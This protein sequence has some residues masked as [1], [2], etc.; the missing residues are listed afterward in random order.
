MFEGYVMFMKAFSLSEIK[1]ELGTLSPARVMALCMR[2]AKYK[3]D[4]KELLT[5]LLFHAH[6]E[7]SYKTNIKSEIDEKFDEINMSNVYYIK[8]SLRKIL[9][10]TNKYIKYSG[11]AQTE[12]ELLLYFCMKIKNAEMPLN[13]SVALE[14]IYLNQIKRLHKAMGKLHEDLQYDFKKEADALL[15]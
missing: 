5:Y 12:T 2:L 6:D 3:K 1:N 10:N 11:S 9:R 4:N 13:K 15:N 8:K 7:E 14:N